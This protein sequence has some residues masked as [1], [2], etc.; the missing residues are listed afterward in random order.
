MKSPLAAQFEVAW[1]A[2]GGPALEEEYQFHP[3]RK[4]RAD[5]CH[6]ASRVLIEIEG[7]VYGQGRHTRATGYIKD[8]EK[9]N[10]ATMLG[11]RVLRIP[12]GGVQPAIV[13]EIINFV[14][15]KDG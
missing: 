1:R 9:Y 5:Y 6:R 7:G 12:T 4:W 15:G 11:Y 10:A 2:L 3:K 13:E 8:C 14:R